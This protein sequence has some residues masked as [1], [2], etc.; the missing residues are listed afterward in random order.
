MPF[1]KLGIPGASTLVLLATDAIVRILGLYIMFVALEQFEVSRVLP[2]IGAAQPIFILALTWV[3]WGPQAM[4]AIDI[5]AFLML[6]TGSIIISIETTPKIT[7]RFLKLTLFSSSMFSLD[8]IFLK[9][10]FSGQPFW[11]GIVWIQLFVFIFA[12]AFLISKKSR[13]EIF[14]KNLVLDKK[15]QALFLG[16]QITGGIGNLLQSFAISLTPVIF[17]ATINALRGIQ[18]AFLF[19]I[20]LV[21]SFL[22]PRVLREELSRRVIFR[23]IISITMIAVGLYLL[24]M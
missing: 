13:K 3:F 15:N 6:F 17:L 24:M 9:L 1:T 14:A 20:T 16:A 19:I 10:I 11:Q 12:L 2:T 21:V 18:Y 22:F 8:Y 7:G 5:L 4:T 23:K